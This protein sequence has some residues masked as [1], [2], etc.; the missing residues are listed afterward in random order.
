MSSVRMCDNP[1]CGEIF[2]E[3]EEGWSVSQQT[4]IIE[5]DSGRRSSINMTLDLC[6]ECSPDTKANA[7]RLREIRKR[8]RIARLELTI[9][10]SL[11]DEL[12][13]AERAADMTE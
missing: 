5:D 3:A 7:A 10:N 6:P 4:K 8:N 12:A 11:D 13:A 1:G 9:G 2:S